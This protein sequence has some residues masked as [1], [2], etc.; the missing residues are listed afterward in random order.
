MELKSGKISHKEKQPK[1]KKTNYQKRLIALQITMGCICAML[2]SGLPGMIAG[3]GYDRDISKLDKEQD[4]I[5]EQFMSSD[6]FSDSFKAEFTKI[7][8]DYANGVI[9]YEKF[10][11]Q[12]EYLNSVKYAQEVLKNSNNSE[13]KT[14]VESIDKQKQER[15]DEFN[16]SLVTKA[17]LTGVT[18][19][20]AASFA[21][22]V[23]FGVYGAKEIGDDMRKKKLLTKLPNGIEAIKSSNHYTSVDRI[24]VDDENDNTLTK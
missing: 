9:D 21:S 11:K 2:A 13:L 23:A 3:K 8:N 20:G 17:S 12:V 14:Q 18:I 1:P 7:S 22:I 10:N 4:A 19:C 6:E 24:V 5:Y 15:T 16:S